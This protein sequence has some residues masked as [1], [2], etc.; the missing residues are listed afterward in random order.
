MMHPE[1]RTFTQK[2]AAVV[3]ATCMPVF[4]ITFVSIPFQLGS[5]PGEM[6]AS[7]VA[8]ERHLT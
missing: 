1:L 4:F 8:V 2:M 6:V 5:Q 7:G 3:I